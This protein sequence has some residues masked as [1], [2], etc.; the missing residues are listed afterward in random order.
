V[1]WARAPL[2]EAATAWPA[3]Q[4]RLPRPKASPWSSR[5]C[6]APSLTSVMAGVNSVPKEGMPTISTGM[7]TH[8]D[9]SVG[10]SRLIAT[11]PVSEYLTGT[12]APR[13]S[14]ARPATGDN[15]ASSP[16]DARNVPAMTSPV[17]P[18]F[19]IRSGASTSST[20]NARPASIVSHSPMPSR[21][22]AIAVKAS[23]SPWGTASRGAGT[24]N[25][26]AISSPPAT[27]ALA[28][29]GPV[30][31]SSAIAP[32]TGPNSAPPTA[33]PMAVPIISPRRSGGASVASQARPPAQVH[34][35]P[36]PCANRAQ[37]RT[38]ATEA[39]PKTSVDAPMSASP[40]KTVFR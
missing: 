14:A 9:A 28:N 1:A 38:A 15:A 30:P 21:R 20:P 4:A 11:A 7:S 3:A 5:W 27:A 18:R 36:S 25:A 23:R 17:T 40:S 26:T 33:A 24:A 35:P 2:P 22:S 19:A 31:I 39:H 8:A 37:S 6:W 29:A 34:A 10:A 13:R 12:M 16:A 32:T